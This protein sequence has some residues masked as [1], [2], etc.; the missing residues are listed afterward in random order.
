MKAQEEE[1][2]LAK[3]TTTQEQLMKAQN[4]VKRATQDRETSLEF[5]KESIRDIGGY[6][7][8]YK[9]DMIHQYDKWESADRKRKDVVIEKMKLFKECVDISQFQSRLV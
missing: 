1:L 9:D 7:Q 6:N 8:K 3:D 4:K 5:Y 2:K